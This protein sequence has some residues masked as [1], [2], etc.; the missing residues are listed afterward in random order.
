MSLTNFRILI[1]FNMICINYLG[2]NFKK[3]RGVQQ[4]VISQQQTDLNE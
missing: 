4:I 1:L 3:W 2:S